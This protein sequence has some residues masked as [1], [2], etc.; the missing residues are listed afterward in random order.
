M[1]F[2]KTG[3]DPHLLRLRFADDRTLDVVEAL[4]IGRDERCDLQLHDERISDRHVELY[5]VG[6]LWWV[7]DVGSAD[8]T[9]LDDECID[10]VPVLRAAELT[11]GAEGPKIWLEPADAGPACC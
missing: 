8:G 10:A 11:L 1:S 2:D 5:R 4:L 9:Y 7:R 6:A 3:H